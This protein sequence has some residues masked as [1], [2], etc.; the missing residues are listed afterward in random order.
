MKGHVRKRGTKWAF[1]IDIGKDPVTGRRKQKWFSGYRTKREAEK[2]MA[3]KIAEISRGDYVEPS[4]MPFRNLMQEWLKMDVKHRLSGRTYEMFEYLIRVYIAPRIGDIPLDKL[5]PLH[6]QQ[7]YNALLDTDKIR[8]EGKLSPTTIRHIHRAIYSALKWGVEMRILPRNI[9]E[10]V[11]PP[12]R[13]RKEMKVWTQEEAAK[14]LNVC[15]GHR[16]YA[17]YYLALST[18]MRRGELLGL[19]WEDVD[20]D[21][22]VIMVR[23][24]LVRHED[25]FTVEEEP[26]TAS[27]RR[28]IHISP[29]TIEV[30]KQHRTKQKEELLRI[31]MTNPEYVFLSVAG[32]FIEPSYVRKIFRSLIKRA[33]V[34][35]IRIH[36]LRHTHATLLLQQG[37]HPKIVSERLGHNSISMTMDLYSH[38]TPSMQK[39]AAMA[40]QAFEESL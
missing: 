33:G 37:V 27:S 30:L 20:L 34:P 3:E 2:A 36:D 15:K 7:F 16:L 4:R 12:K 22:G 38:V 11:H 6:I 18:G 8:G 19:K 5:S 23:R 24:T 28:S 21:R 13:V 35:L 14:F 17:F 39:E 25:G 32:K 1:V 40:L 9:S 26:K 31:G 29:Q 10:N